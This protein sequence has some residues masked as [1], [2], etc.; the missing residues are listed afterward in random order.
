MMTLMVMM[1][2][3]RFTMMKSVKSK[4]KTVG[5]ISLMSCKITSLEYQ[6]SH[7]TLTNI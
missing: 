2:V 6:Y 5:I 7:N 4:I 3:L 1:M